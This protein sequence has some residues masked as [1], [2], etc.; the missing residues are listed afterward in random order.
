MAL[1]SSHVRVMFVT[2]ELEPLISTGGLGAAAAGVVRA[3]RAGGTA[4]EVV[5]PDIGGV[6]LGDQIDRRIA[7]PDW[8]GPASLR[9]GTHPIAGPVHLLGVPGLDRSHPYVDPASGRGW[10]DN[11]HR[12]FAWSCAAAACVPHLQPDVVHVNDWHAA[13]T[14]GHL[15]PRL[16]TVLTIHNL[17]HQGAA[18]AGWELVLGERADRYRH[19]GGVNALAG[20]IRLADRVI[21]V[22]PRYADEIRDDQHGMGLAPLLRER[23]TALLGILNGIDAEVWNPETDPHLVARYG[24]ATVEAKAT[25]AAALCGELGLATS[26]GPLICVVSRFDHQKAIDLVLGAVD[27]IPRLPARLAILG[28]G[29]R[30]VEDWAVRA[31]A[32]HPDHVSFRRGYDVGLSHR[33]FASAD[34][35]VM[36]SRFEP[37]GL[38]QMQAMRYGTIP[39]VTDVGGLHDSVVDVDAAPGAGTG[40]VMWAPDPAALVDG[41]HRGVRL[42]SNK[43]RRSGAIRRGMERDWS[44]TSPAARYAEVYREVMADRHVAV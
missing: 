3:L 42:W 22:S 6:E 37:C 14:L 9:S 5:L 23:G 35:T 39:L 41:L 40:I 19:G 21:T 26:P 11:D 8:V 36:P 25:N 44:W 33:M 27:A 32:R 12:F 29:E 13:T 4:V 20:A 17:A 2:A 31:S 38:T 28:S 34:L 15:D 30:D 18:D 43:A 24:P 1:P 10:A 7:A 16:A